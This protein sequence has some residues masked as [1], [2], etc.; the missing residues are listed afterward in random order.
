ML[1]WCEKHPEERKQLQKENVE[2]FRKWIEENP[3]K[4]LETQKRNLELG[5][6]W[7]KE[8]PEETQKII[9]KNLCNRTSKEEQKIYDYLLSLGFPIERQV[10]LDGHYFDFKINNFLIEYNGSTYHYTKFENLNNPKS[11]APSTDIKDT[12]YHRNIRDI[13]IKNGYFVIQ[14]WDFEWLYKRE[15]IQRLLKDQL[16][17]TANYKDYIEESSLL[18]ND[19]GFIIDGEQIEPK[20]IWVATNKKRLVESTYMEGKVLV[21][22]SGY[23]LIK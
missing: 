2:R 11:K 19:Y 9:Q 5:H 13:A 14:I 22:N 4:A 23:T 8:H 20:S 12:F 21:Y 3:D 15:F 17:G 6:I 1:D 7:W 16:S 10:F 18:N